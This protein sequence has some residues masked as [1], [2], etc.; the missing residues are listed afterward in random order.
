M[1]LLI[2]GASGA[3]LQHTVQVHLP[4]SPSR[5]HEQQCS[6]QQH[7]QLLQSDPLHLQRSPQSEMVSKLKH[8]SGMLIMYM[9][10]SRKIKYKSKPNSPLPAF[11]TCDFV[12]LP[13][14]AKTGRDIKGKEGEFCPRCE[15]KYESRNLEIIKVTIAA[16]QVERVDLR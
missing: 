16:Q 6:E 14:I 8:K 13:E 10:L 11:S 3:V 9:Y 12:V 15:C 7:I 1:V 4:G 2:T 5:V